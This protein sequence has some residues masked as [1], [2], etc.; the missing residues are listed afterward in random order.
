MATILRRSLDEGNVPSTCKV[1]NIIPIHK[2]KSRAAAKNYRPVALTSI[3]SKI[4]EKVI[5]T[6][7]VSF[8]DANNLFNPSQHGF[9]ANR[10]CLSQLLDHCDRISNLL[11]QGYGVD[12]I[13]LDFAKAF[14]KVDHNITLAKLK[15]LGISGRLGAWLK[16]FLVG[17]SQRVMV[18]GICSEAEPVRSG[19]PQGS[20]LGPLLFLILIGDIDQNVA[21]SFLSSFADDTRVGREIKCAA[22]HKAL[23]DDLHAVFEWSAA[24]NMEFNSDKFELLSY[25]PSQNTTLPP[26]VYLSND[27]T[28][29][30]EKQCLRDLGVTIANDATF[31][32]F[33]AEKCSA[34]RG[35][36]AWV[37]R[38]FETRA[39]LPLLTLWKTFIRFHIEYCSQ[40]WC[41]T[42]LGDIQAIERLQVSYL[43]AMPAL[44][45]LNYWQQIKKLG[46]HSL[47]RRRERYSIIYAWRILEGLS[48]NLSSTPITEV[49]N[50]RRGRSCVV[51]KV[52]MYAPSR[53]QNIR[54]S[55]FAVRGPQLFNSLPG[56]LRDMRDCALAE[57]KSALDSF[58][59]TIPDEPRLPGLTAESRL[60]SNSIT[61]WATWLKQQQREAG[62]APALETCS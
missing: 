37:L 34:V 10:S 35:T 58:L 16:S 53:L 1:A 61:Q 3:I 48:P 36:T 20:V 28:V 8:L 17:R 50:P 6:R 14:D 30:E 7:L 13:Y 24:N 54:E 5:R 33:I 49:V 45:G 59:K 41:P 2:G 26:P 12:V 39:T 47:E 23:Q 42:K 57:F 21:S 46:L 15:S 43:R 55:S 56:H 52:P 40:L 38:S 11:A 18:Q 31:S 19:V 29:I 9:R 22:D 62:P 4:F 44:R 32:K 27:G 60:P 25:R 51:P